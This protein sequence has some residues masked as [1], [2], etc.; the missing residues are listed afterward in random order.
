M[1]VDFASVEIAVKRGM[2]D[3]IAVSQDLKD[4]NPTPSSLLLD[5]INTIDG[6]I[7]QT[8]SVLAMIPRSSEYEEWHENHYL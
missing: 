1:A 5:T 8:G 6:L 3:L 2:D 7:A 4:N